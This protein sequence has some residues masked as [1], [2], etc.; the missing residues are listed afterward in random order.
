MNSNKNNGAEGAAKGVTSTL[1]NLAGGVSKTAGGLVGSAGK[2]L[3]DT[4]NNTTGTK[5][6]GDGL[7]SVTGGIEDAGNSA[8]KGAEDA[9]QWKKS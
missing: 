9:G 8:G 7:Q 4:I 3:G 5:A 1:G 6:A 2:G